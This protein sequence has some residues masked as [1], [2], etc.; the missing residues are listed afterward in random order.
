M[1]GLDGETAHTDNFATKLLIIQTACIV[2]FAAFATYP[3]ATENGDA[4][5]EVGQYYAMFQDVHVMIFIGFGFL[6]TFLRKHNFNSLGQTF[7]IGALCIQLDIVFQTLVGWIING[8]KLEAVLSVQTMITGDFAAATVLISLGAVLGRV[9]YTQLIYMTFL[10]LIFYALNMHIGVNEYKTVDMGGSMY[11]HTFGAY[12]G[13]AFSWMLGAPTADEQL[14]ESSSYNSDV[15]SL[16]GSV[17]LWMYWPSFNGALAGGDY[18]QQERVVINTIMSL[19]CSCTAAFAFSHWYNGK[20]DMVHI[21]NATLAG[22]VAIGSASDLVVGPWAATLVGFI[23]GTVSVTGYMY[24]TPKINSWG[25]YDV[26]GINNLHG[27]P[28]LIGGITGAIAAGLASENTYGENIGA[29]F[30]ARDEGRTATAQALYQLLAL[31]TTF[32]FSIVGGLLSGKL[33]VSMTHGKETLFEDCDEWDLPEEVQFAVR[34]EDKEAAGGA[35]KRMVDKK[36][37]VKK[38]PVTKKTTE[39]QKSLNKK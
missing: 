30:G 7:L 26:C 10:E 2:F 12:F 14:E 21:Q 3:D 32:F 35:Y 4:Y 11:V 22:G 16:L 38:A 5:L 34:K 31:V 23:A 37:P 19:T 28:G 1:K 24:F 18:H 15:F 20:L 17:F 8:G 36:D 33:V 13:L 29:I 25:V 6:M 27:M 39:L 9:T